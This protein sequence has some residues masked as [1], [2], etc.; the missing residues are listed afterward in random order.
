[1]WLHT[2]QKS[3]KKMQAISHLKGTS[4]LFSRVKAKDELKAQEKIKATFKA[5]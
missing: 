5:K 2:M 4:D 1:M 3:K